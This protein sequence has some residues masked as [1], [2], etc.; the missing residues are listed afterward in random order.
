MTHPLLLP[1]SNTMTNPFGPTSEL[2]PQSDHA[3]WLLLCLGLHHLFFGPNNQF[4]LTLL[5]CL[6]QFLQVLL[7]SHFSQTSTQILPYQF[8]ILYLVYVNN[9]ATIPALYFLIVLT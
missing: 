1:T 7:F 2:Q 4:T 9:K 5:H 6:F 3:F 8:G